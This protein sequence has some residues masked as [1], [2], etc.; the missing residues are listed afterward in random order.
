MPGQK[1]SCLLLT[2]AFVSLC[3]SSCGRRPATSKVRRG[4]VSECLASES[5]FYSIV[6]GHDYSR[7]PLLRPWHIIEMNN[8]LGLV[9]E[10]EYVLGEP[11]SVG[12]K[13]GVFFGTSAARE[14]AGRTV[15]WV[16]SPT[17]TPGFPVF[18]KFT[19]RE[20]WVAHLGFTP[21]PGSVQSVRTAVSAFGTGRDL[22]AS[23][24]K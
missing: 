21:P 2:L 22:F 11:E 10:T 13:D 16:L 3:C 9:N 8:D 23:E 7:L 18:K 20:E 1:Q 5:V 19:S 14:D 17:E 6:G 15:F 4:D 24:R 12:A